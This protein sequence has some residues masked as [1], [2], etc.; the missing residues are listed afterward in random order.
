MPLNTS[1]SS[2][3]LG[4]FTSMTQYQVATIQHITLQSHWVGSPDERLALF[5]QHQGKHGCD[6]CQEE[7]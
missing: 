7:V 5:H 3:L 2:V 6:K 1:Q 4:A